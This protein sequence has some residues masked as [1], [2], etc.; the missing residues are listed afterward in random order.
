M[1]FQRCY[2]HRPAA[3]LVECSR[4]PYAGGQP[5][6]HQGGRS[7]V[8]LT[9]TIDPMHAVEQQ[10]G[11]LAMP[12]GSV[13]ILEPTSLVLEQRA[14]NCSEIAE[15]SSTTGRAGIPA[16]VDGSEAGGRTGSSDTATEKSE[17]TTKR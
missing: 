7:P 12:Q 14:V 3:R 2:V 5:L 6:V 9:M 8:H 16:I 10:P 1:Q 15:D 11:R 17:K 13:M 4:L